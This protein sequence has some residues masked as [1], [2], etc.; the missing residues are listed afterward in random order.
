MGLGAPA[1][2]AWLS[3]GTLGRGGRRTE[4]G[5]QSGSRIFSW[6]EA[7]RAEMDSLEGS[8]VRRRIVDLPGFEKSHTGRG[9]GFS[10]QVETPAALRIKPILIHYKASVHVRGHQ[11]GAHLKIQDLWESGLGS[12]DVFSAL[13]R[14]FCFTAKHADGL[15]LLSKA[16]LAHGSWL[17]DSS[18]QQRA[19]RW[20]RLRHPVRSGWEAQMELG[21][22]LCSLQPP[23]AHSPP[24]PR[25]SGSGCLLGSRGD[26]VGGNQLDSFPDH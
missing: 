17:R 5:V 3:T 21:A 22:W 11:G 14:E 1:S 4:E 20:C 26:G 13:S 7:E 10:W 23:G 19:W 2:K 9:A 18:T 24:H 6:G 8:L 15:A 16:E 12:K 25:L